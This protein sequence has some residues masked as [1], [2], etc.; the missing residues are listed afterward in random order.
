MEEWNGVYLLWDLGLQVPN[1]QVHTDVSDTWGC[2]V[3]LDP[4]FMWS[5]HPGFVH[6]QLQ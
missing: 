4:G 3:F 5:G 1:L 2:G 6:G